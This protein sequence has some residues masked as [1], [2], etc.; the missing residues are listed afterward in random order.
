MIHQP[1][2]PGC[3][4]RALAWAAAVLLVLALALVGTLGLGVV[5]AG[6]WGVG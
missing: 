2:R 5:L 4:E 6:T 3:P 1:C